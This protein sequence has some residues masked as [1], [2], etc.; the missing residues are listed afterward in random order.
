MTI[1]P[2][3]EQ[4]TPKLRHRIEVGRKLERV[5]MAILTLGISECPGAS[6]LPWREAAVALLTGGIS[7]C[8]KHPGTYDWGD[9][10]ANLIT[11]GLVGILRDGKNTHKGN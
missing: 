8:K 1:R 4:T 10:T 9:A 2:G 3:F 7:E 5:A 11:L 6:E